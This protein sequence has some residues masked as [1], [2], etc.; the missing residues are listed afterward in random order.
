VASWSVDAWVRGNRIT[1]PG[2]S[3]KYAQSETIKHPMGFDRPMSG[4]AQGMILI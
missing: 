1:G 4:A 2:E 3:Y